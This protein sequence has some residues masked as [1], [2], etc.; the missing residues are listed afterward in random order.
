MN[1]HSTIPQFDIPSFNGAS[2][3]FGARGKDYL[4]REQLGPWYDLNSRTPY[5]K[6]V[7][8]LFF[9][10]GSLVDYG[11]QWKAGVDQPKAGAALRAL[12][13]SWDPKHEIKVGTIAVMLA[14]HCDLISPPE[15]AVRDIAD[16]CLEIS[17]PGGLK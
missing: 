2:V 10:G 4:T 6:A 15:E 9:K 11:L 3:A 14:N 7:N 8:G 1:D 12:M 17:Q 16:P 5:H 13:S